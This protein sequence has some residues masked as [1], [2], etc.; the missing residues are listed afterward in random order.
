[1]PSRFVF[2]EG[3]DAGPRTLAGGAHE[4]EDF[5]EL[6]FVG[7]AREKG[8]AG[9]HFGH[10]AAGGPDVDAGVVG[11]RTEQDIG[12]AI[13]EGDDFVGEGVDGDAKGSRK[14]E[15]GELELTFVVD[16]KI[17]GLEVAMQDAVLVAKGDALEELVHE[18]FDGHVV[19][20]T[21][22]AARVH[23]LLEVFVHVFEDEHEL[24]LGV[25]D[26]VEG[27][28]VFMLELFH[29]GNFADGGGGGAFFAVEVDFFEGD[30]F[31]GLAVATLEDGRIGAFAELCER[32]VSV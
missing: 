11:A 6:V 14:T 24:V 27:D 7:G 32:G 4:A 19:E 5:L 3:G 22:L 16:E 18:G 13:P 26:V 23:E 2:G 25:N 10:D 9:V 8:P 1:M 31:A 15:I 30:E 17:L 20:L 12:S 28:D 29:E 21:A